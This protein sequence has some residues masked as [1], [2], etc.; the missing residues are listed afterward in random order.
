M[1]VQQQEQQQE[2]EGRQDVSKRQLS[3][4]GQEQGSQ[5][6]K[7]GAHPR[8]LDYATRIS[9]IRRATTTK[10]NQVFLL[11]NDAGDILPQ[12]HGYG[13]YFRDMCY[14]DRMELRLQGELGVPLLADASAGYQAV[15]ELT[16]PSLRLPDGRTL[17]KERLSVR[18]VIALRENLTQTV[19][20][21]NLDQ[22]GV[23]LDA[24][25]RFA[26]HFADMFTIRGAPPEERGALRPP[27]THRDKVILEY[28][29]AD[30]HK[31]TTRLAFSRSRMTSTGGGRSTISS[32]S[33]ASAPPS[34]SPTSSRMTAQAATRRPASIRT[35]RG[36]ASTPRS[37]RSWP[38][39]R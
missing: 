17:S 31:R 39:C 5:A 37:R 1:A 7:S 36:R 35:R 24:E 13:M 22:V 15:F 6:T 11:T 27:E 14:L 32:S 38:T 26:S 3:Q 34:R 30:K 19:E 29:G 16:N 23:E 21:H 10:Y 9:D 18:R 33:P 25:L 4:Q 12:D 28:D 20:I 8:R 2:Q